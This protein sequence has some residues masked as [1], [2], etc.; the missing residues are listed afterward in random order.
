L[1]SEKYLL[2][3]LFILNPYVPLYK[4]YKFNMLVMTTGNT[5]LHE[6]VTHG[7][8]EVALRL[9]EAKPDVGHMLNERKESPLHIAA[10]EGLTMVVKEILKQPW[11]EREEETMPGVYGTGSVLHQAVLGGDIG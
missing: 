9:L 1:F 6:A 2:Y 8:Y 3:L 5:A 10:R 4:I 7:K 11:I